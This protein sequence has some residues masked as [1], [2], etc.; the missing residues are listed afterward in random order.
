MPQL[1]H[2]ESSHA[3]PSSHKRSSQ[4]RPPAP[5]PLCLERKVTALLERMLALYIWSLNFCKD[6]FFAC[7]FFYT[8]VFTLL[9]KCLQVQCKCVIC[10]SVSMQVVGSPIF[11][12]LPLFQRADGKKWQPSNKSSAWVRN[13]SVC[14]M[15]L[16]ETC[17]SP[18]RCNSL[19]YPSV[20]ITVCVPSV[21]APSHPLQPL[22]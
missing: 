5:N 8:K 7:T 2:P 17:C 20:C 19:S 21:W 15:A 12:T 22:S 4:L 9:C 16:A 14:N 18:Y 11:N 1:P 10:K 13:A 3:C 6:L